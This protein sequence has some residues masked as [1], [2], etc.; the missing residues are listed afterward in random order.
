MQG[1]NDVKGTLNNKFIEKEE[2]AISGKIY[3]STFLH[4]RFLR[5]S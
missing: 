2:G 4:Q 1:T 3:K 5:R